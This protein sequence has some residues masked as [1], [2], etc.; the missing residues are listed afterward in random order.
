[1]FIGHFA[2]ALAGK[3]AAPHTPLGWLFA[4]CQLPDLIWPMLLLAGVERARVAPGDTAFTPLAFEHYPWSHSLLMVV[5]GGVMIGSVYRFRRGPRRGAIVLAALVVSHWVLDW[6]THRQDLP[7]AP[8]GERRLGLGMWNSVPA[9]LIVEGLLFVA[10]VSLYWRAT[11]SRDRIGSAAWIGLVGFL[12]LIQAANAFGPPPPHIG[13]VAVAGLGI[14]LLVLWGGWTDRHR[15]T[16][17]GDR[18]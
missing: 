14:W 2:V 16:A 9:T 7:L 17:G 13:A 18:R 10:G 4:A 5:L 6:V 15:V 8:W 12:V 11:R 1:M 3:R